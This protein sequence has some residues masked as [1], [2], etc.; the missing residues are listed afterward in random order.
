[1]SIAVAFYGPLTGIAIRLVGA[2]ESSLYIRTARVAKRKILD[3]SID[4]THSGY[5]EGDA[6][7]AL[8]FK[9]LPQADIEQAKAIFEGETLVYISCREGYFSGMISEFSVVGEALNIKYETKEKINE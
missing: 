4:L 7:I 8:K 2:E 6:S 5:T 3:G 1:M 9:N